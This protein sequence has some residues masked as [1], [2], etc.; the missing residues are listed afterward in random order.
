MGISKIF[1]SSQ[2]YLQ[3]LFA[4]EKNR[5]HLYKNKEQINNLKHEVM[6]KNITPKRTTKTSQVHD[7]LIAK[8]SITSW[9]A[10]ELY[11]ATRLSDIIFRLRKVGEETNSF[12]IK[13]VE[14][15]FVDRLG[16]KNSYAK[17]VYIKN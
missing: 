11:C 12:E 7:H 3:N 5:V 17:Y 16:N 13:T 9:E 15:D 8:G 2:K 14:I 1:Q 6:Q 10:I 4:K